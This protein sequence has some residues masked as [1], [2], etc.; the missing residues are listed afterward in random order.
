ME[1]M[2]VKKIRKSRIKTQNKGPLTGF[3]RSLFTF[4]DFSLKE[5][6]NIAIE[7]IL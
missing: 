6:K 3:N 4:P 7:K 1:E 5:H 2:N